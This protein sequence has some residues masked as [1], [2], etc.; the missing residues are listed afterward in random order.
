MTDHIVGVMFARNEMDVIEE[1]I[2]S[3]LP[4]LDSLFISDDGSTDKTWDIVKGLK[5]NYKKIEHIQQ[6]PDKNDKGQRQSL[7]NEIRRRYK[8]ENT[9][10]QTIEADVQILDTSVRDAIKNFAQADSIV[11]WLMMNAVRPKGTWKDVDLYPNWGGKSIR[12]I[13]PMCHR[14]EELVY[15][16]RPY[17]DV[18]FTDVWKP[19]P[20]GY[21][22]YLGNSK[23][24]KGRW[25][26]LL[27][28]YGYR[29]PRHFWMKYKSMGSHHTKYKDWDLT[30]IESVERTVPFF[31]GQWNGPGS[32]FMS[33][34][35]IISS[36]GIDE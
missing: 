31:N 8:A 12:E 36:S 34:Y 33:R 35:S 1:T 14:L 9:F 20:V 32:V 29:S 7:L 25:R 10:C 24:R 13:M 22:K 28:H 21:G 11:T 5:Q 26:P 15:S 19:Y 27:A 18:Q 30:S 4:H 6:K 17:P 2:T 23:A 3:V 16:W